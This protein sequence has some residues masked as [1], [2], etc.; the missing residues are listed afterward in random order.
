MKLRHL[1]IKALFFYNY[2]VLY[3][4]VA[5]SKSHITENCCAP[6]LLASHSFFNTANFTQSTVNLAYRLVC[7][8]R[9]MPSI[10]MRSTVFIN[11]HKSGKENN[12]TINDKQKLYNI[13]AGLIISSTIL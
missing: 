13:L 11:L 7:T 1:K 8:A 10:I 2:Q 5:G 6:K 4:K 3:G 12:I 9:P